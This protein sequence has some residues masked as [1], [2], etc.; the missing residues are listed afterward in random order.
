MSK[1]ISVFN[2]KGGVGKTTSTVNIGVGLGMKGKKVLI[3]DLDPQGHATDAL[4]F[5]SSELEFVIADLFE[6]V[7]KRQAYD[8]EKYIIKGKYIDLLPSNILLSSA[9]VSVVTATTREYLLKKIL[10]P[11]KDQ[12][13]YILIDCLPSLGMLAINALTASDY[14]FVPIKAQALDARAIDLLLNTYSLIKSETNPQLEIL[15]FFI[16]MYDQR[17]KLAKN[18]IEKIRKEYSEEY[19]IRLFE[20]YISVNTKAAEAA[21]C[22]IPVYEYDANGK[23]ADEYMKIVEEIINHE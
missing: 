11:V 12:Y 15:G 21:G 7:I 6:A 14:V 13:D 16:T 3:V 9:D 2:Q 22:G 23:T 4:G 5:E 17:T 18:T 8:T 20:P 10:A 19:G 1:I